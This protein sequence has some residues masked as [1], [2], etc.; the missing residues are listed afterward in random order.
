MRVDWAGAIENENLGKIFIGGEEFTG[1]GYQ[2]LMTVNTK[3]YV[4]EPTRANDGSISNIDDHD[5]FIVPRC[6][7]NFKFF[8]I[9]DYQRLCRVLNSANQFPVSYFDKQFGEHRTYMMYAEPEEMAKIYNV[10]TS[11][12]GVLDYEVSFIGTLNNLEIFKVMYVPKYWNG[13]SLVDMSLKAIDFSASTTYTKGQ[14]VYWNGSYY[15]A[16]YYENSF[17]EIPTT[18]AQY[19]QVKTPTLWNDVTTY[20]TGDLVYVDTTSGGNAVRKY[21]EA[22]KENFYGFLT[23]NREYWSEVSISQYSDDKTYT[24]GNYVY[25]L[26]GD[27]K[28]FY[29]AIYY[30]ETFSGE[31]PD[32]TKYWAKVTPQINV[33]KDVDWG[34]SIHILTATDLADFYQ[35]PD[36]KVFKG[37]NTRADGTGLNILPNSNWSVFENTTIYP[38]IGV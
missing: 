36:G 8:N 17:K 24:K 5:T 2:G 11:V 14:K 12:I 37:W 34:K 18:N 9:R 4:E 15:E 6:K 27:N 25:V 31:S 22:K 21:Y 32:N 13:T 7:V 38:I 29:K 3:T 20:T 23:S 1:I 28:V 26:D 19:W 35:I 16:I 33:E 10:S 30:K